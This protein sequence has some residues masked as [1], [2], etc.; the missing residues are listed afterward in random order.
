MHTNVAVKFCLCVKIKERTIDAAALPPRS[1]QAQNGSALIIC[2]IHTALYN[3][4]RA[5]TET[6]MAGTHV[7]FS[8][9]VNAQSINCA[10]SGG[11]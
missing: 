4:K 1:T 5:Y 6:C 3:N 7:V 8:P 10:A 11:M 9:D 2:S